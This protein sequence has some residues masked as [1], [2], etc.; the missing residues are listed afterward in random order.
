M[1]IGK[2]DYYRA[3]DFFFIKSL[4]QGS[5][6]HDL[7]SIEGDKGHVNNVYTWSYST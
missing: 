6:M 2:K 7:R 4:T 1:V 3:D 5:M